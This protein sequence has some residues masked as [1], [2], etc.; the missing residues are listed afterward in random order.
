MYENGI[1]VGVQGTAREIT[2][3]KRDEEAL[4][5]SEEQYRILF[6]SNPQPMWVYD[7]DT[8]A[9]LAVN[10]AA[11]KH[12]GYSREAFLSMSLQDIYLVDD[13]T[14]LVGWARSIE[15]LV[16]GGEWSH[17]TSSGET[18]NVEI[19]ANVIEFSN[20]KAGLLL[21]NDITLHKAAEPSPREQLNTAIS[22]TGSNR[23][24]RGRRSSRFQ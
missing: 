5:R 20:R 11:I 14:R 12:Y 23:T 6:E 3:R 15:E 13:V 9:F 19:T 7:L 10:E 22:E 16:Q 8:L 4:R 2:A 21:V 24:A 17:C 18:I 1:P